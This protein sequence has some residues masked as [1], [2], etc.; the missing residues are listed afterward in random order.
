VIHYRHFIRYTL[1]MMKRK[2][3][4]AQNLPTFSRPVDLIFA[5]GTAMISGFVDLFRE[6]FVEV[7]FPIEVAEMRLA[8]NPLKAVAAGCL[9]AALAE[10]RALHEASI[11]VAP[12]ALVRGAIRGIPK[13]DPEAALQLARLQSASVVPE[14]AV[15]QKGDGKDGWGRGRGR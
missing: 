5:G 15:I 12:A 8:A 4:G 1:E 10:T 11:D 6:E 13:A 3:E 14:D 7:D 2:M 9:Q